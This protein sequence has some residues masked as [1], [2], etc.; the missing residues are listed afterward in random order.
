VSKPSERLKGSVCVR[1]RAALFLIGRRDSDKPGHEQENRITH[2]DYFFSDGPHEERQSLLKP[3]HDG[4][5]AGD[6]ALANEG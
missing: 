3:A 4:E 5:D 2:L 1:H 6:G